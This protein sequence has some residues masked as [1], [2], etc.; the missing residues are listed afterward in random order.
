MVWHTDGATLAMQRNHCWPPLRI[1]KQQTAQHLR[2]HLGKQRCSVAKATVHPASQSC[3]VK[4]QE[5]KLLQH[6]KEVRHNSIMNMHVHSDQCKRLK[7]MRDSR[8]HNSRNVPRRTEGAKLPM[9][10]PPG[11]AKALL[12][13]AAESRALE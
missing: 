10:L 3:A 11:H 6:I 7:S 8:L 1:V 4:Q 5:P 2:T 9:Q 13:V 12:V